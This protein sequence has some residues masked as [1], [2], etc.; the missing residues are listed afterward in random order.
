MAKQQE[1]A[2]RTRRALIEA[3]AAEIDRNGYDRTSL[4][5]IC[6]LARISMGALTFHFPSKGELADEISQ[7]GGEATRAA[8]GRVSVSELPELHVVVELTLALA[9][10]LEEDARVRSAARLARER[11]GAA[12]PWIGSWLPAVRDLL[13][14][15]GEDG[16]LRAGAA[17]G[18][19]AA[20]VVYVMA[21]VEAYVRAVAADGPGGC[22]GGWE[23]G[24]AG[25]AAAK[26]DL[27]W[28]LVLHGIEAEPD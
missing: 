13:A 18:A 22:P 16:Q 7:L 20:L 21:G 10:L 5:R 1:R 25:D 28:E 14:R 6:Q 4:V 12:E 15:A 26:L 27:I 8:V 24:Q 2:E 23:P 9:R 19:V 11:P 3:A 17:P